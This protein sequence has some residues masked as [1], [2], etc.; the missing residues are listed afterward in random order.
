MEIDGLLRIVDGQHRIE[1]F[2]YLKENDTNKYEQ[3]KNF[4]FPVTILAIDEG[5]VVEEMDAFINSRNNKAKK[6]STD[7][8]IHLSN[9][10]R[11]RSD[12]M[13]GD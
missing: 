3:Y 11:N 10:I 5:Q 7:L 1:G 8:A 2:R 13:N 9:A 6:I 12:K 4:E